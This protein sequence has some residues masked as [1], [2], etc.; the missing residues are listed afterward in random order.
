MRVHPSDFVL[1]E[2]YL[3]QGKEHQA[4][5]AHLVRCPKCVL[6]FQGVIERPLE[7]GF[8]GDEA[9]DPVAGFRNE[10]S[11]Q[12]E[13]LPGV[14]MPLGKERAAAPA[15]FVELMNLSEEQRHLLIRNSRRFRTRG[16]CELL[17]DRCMETAGRNPV[18]AEGLALL[19]LEIVAR[20]DAGASNKTDGLQARAW[21]YLG[22]AR[23]VR[24]DLQGAEDAFLRADTCLKR[25]SRDSVDDAIFLDLKASLC[26][27]RRD[28]DEALRLLAQAVAIYR[29][30]GHP[31]R[32]GKCLVNMNTVY[33]YAGR[34]DQGIPVLYEAIELI[35]A[36]QEPRLDLCARHN[37]IDDLT[38][39]GRFLEAQ[40][41]YRETR[42]RY[43]SFPDA[44]TQNRRKWVKGKIC[45]GLGRDV[46]A[47]RLFLAARDGF[48][49]EG[50][51]YDTALVSLELAILYARDRRTADLKRLSQKILPIFS[52]L[53]VHREALAALSF[54]QK[55]L[56]SEKA[57]V[58]LVSRIADF[59][60]RAEHDPELRFEP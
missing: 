39:M 21:A 33:R 48:I 54:L 15:L 37:L 6:R 47:E 34:P 58:E 20:L 27:A 16:L 10:G 43:R 32:A 3:S 31:H 5:L 4:L 57:S 51:P 52:S 46:Q 29:R 42:C 7:S 45:A 36:D 17:L 30:A 11:V 9:C 50:M 23:R 1:E 49:V 26:R 2:L 38:D 14:E 44:V 25:G 56:T 60:R 40:R 22:N 59:L 41:L 53:H 24:S 8:G 19:A 12:E 28:F 13:S 35:D 18:G 55:A